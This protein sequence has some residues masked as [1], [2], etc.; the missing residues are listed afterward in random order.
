MDLP[1]SSS[2]LNKDE[3]A[4]LCIRNSYIMLP[5]CRG[6]PVKSSR[7]DEP[8][9]MLE[10]KQHCLPRIA[11]S[12]KT[13]HRY[14][15][16]V[17]QLLLRVD[18]LSHLQV[19]RSNSQTEIFTSSAPLHTGRFVMGSFVSFCA[20]ALILLQALQL[21]LGVHGRPGAGAT[22]VEWYRTAQNTP[23]RLSPQPP[24]S[25]GADFPS[26]A[27]VKIDR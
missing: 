8:K 26:N 16:F 19:S 9:S 18:G 2:F 4:W 13:Q 6:S 10:S 17:V 25:F 5:A 15:V 24:F 23:D 14:P 3:H 12:P 22:A 20:C 27:T 1:I 11:P 7:V 21:Q